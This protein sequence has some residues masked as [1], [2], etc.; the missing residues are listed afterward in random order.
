MPLG[1]LH[2]RHTVRPFPRIAVMQ[3]S[4]TLEMKEPEYESLISRI[5]QN[6]WFQK[7]SRPFY[8]EWLIR[9]IPWPHTRVAFVYFEGRGPSSSCT[10]GLLFSRLKNEKGILEWLRQIGCERF[11]KYFLYNAHCGSPES[12]A[13]ALKWPLDR[14]RAVQ[15]FVDSF[16][17]YG[18]EKAF[19]TPQVDLTCYPV[20]RVEKD[21]KK[22]YLSWL[23][24][25]YARG[26]Y[27]VRHRALKK[28][29]DSGKFARDEWRKV[30]GLIGLLE[31][32]NRKQTTL[33]RTLNLII[34]LHKTYFLTGTEEKMKPL[35]QRQAARRLGLAASTISRLCRSRALITP[36]GEEKR[37]GCFFPSRKSWL[38]H[39]LK[40][41]MA[42]NPGMGD[43]LVQKELGLRFKTDISRRL[44]NLYRH[45]IQQGENS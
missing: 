36:W 17:L 45:Q 10:E 20:A 16:L 35:T 42:D 6:P 34:K 12:I 43:A 13:L 9:R 4:E 18:E 27:L 21:G 15:N 2:I 1:T 33:V 26:R 40:R 32:I 24:L 11:E 25:H 37:L 44:V 3:V 29:K 7:L 8:G 19:K 38:F 30:Q 31:R 23:A 41:I 14:V 5:E 39:R 22:V 28:L